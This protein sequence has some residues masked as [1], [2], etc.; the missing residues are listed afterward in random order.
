MAYRSEGIKSVIWIHAGTRDRLENGF[1][2]M[3][4]SIDV[5]PDSNVDPFRVVEAWLRD[6]KNGPWLMVVDNVDDTDVVFSETS[7]AAPSQ[8]LSCIPEVSHG[9]VIFIT[10]WKAV[11]QKL[12]RKDHVHLGEMSDAQGTELIRSYLGSDLDD[13]SETEEL[14]KEL[15]RELGHIP[16]AITH[17]AAYMRMC[18]TGVADYLE[19]YRNS[20]EDQ[21]DLMAPSLLEM[22]I[23]SPNEA[24]EDVD[25][26]VL[27]AWLM[28]FNNIKADKRAGPLAIDILSVM[29]FLDG[30]DIPRHLFKDFRPKTLY[31]QYMV[32]FGTLKSFSMLQQ[33]G[34]TDKMRFRVH[35]LVQLAMRRWLEQHDRADEY[36]RDALDLV[37]ASFPADAVAEWNQSVELHP[38]AE[39]VLKLE[40]VPASSPARLKLLQSVAAF[41]DLS[42]QYETA[43]IKWEEVVRL[44]TETAGA[45]DVQTLNAR[46]S[47]AQTLFSAAKFDEAEK[48]LNAVLAAKKKSAGESDAGVLKTEHLLAEIVSQRGDHFQAE[49]LHREIYDTREKLLGGRHTD[50]LKSAGKLMM[51]LWEL[52]RFEEAETLADKTLDACKITLGETHPDTLGTADTLGFILE[53]RGKLIEAEELKGS[54][55]EKRKSLYGPNHPSTADSEHDV[56]WVLH[57]LGRYG[58]ARPHYEQALEKKCLLLGEDHW[59][60][61]TTKCN[62]P[63]FYCDQGDYELAEKHSRRIILDFKRTRGDEHPQTLDALGGLAV[64]L[65]HRGKLEDAAKTARTS[66]DGRNKVIGENHPWTQPPL[67][68]WGH[69]LTLQGHVEQGETVMRAALARMEETLG[70]DHGYVF[71]ALLQL[72]KNLALRDGEGALEEAEALARRALAGREKSLGP[73]HPYTFKAM[74]HLA[75][76][77]ARRRTDDEA[78]M[79]LRGAQIGLVESLGPDHPDAI[80]CTRELEETA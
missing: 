31:T 64:I 10:R 28:S 39:Y 8:L 65:R 26:P 11:A 38:H 18:C 41:Q 42:G 69:V 23:Q 46:D 55:L 44:L 54:I 80:Q 57:Q 37:A 25:F 58:E 16:L 61:L 4:K 76:V 6:P 1:R 59:K 34:S 5:E 77:L 71:T 17:A 75:R 13:S 32:A 12:T 74:W 14:T 22:D 19:S 36:A 79:L 68:H 3:L 24:Y 29:S 60:A 73:E 45:E 49:K 51:E 40:A 20:T 72:S 9:S 66:I 15:L 50:T 48:V 30:N 70:R 56:G 21:Q 62:L 2:G 67:C 53:C 43:R 27:K 47:V 63:V 78:A 33:S 35:R 52:G 7:G